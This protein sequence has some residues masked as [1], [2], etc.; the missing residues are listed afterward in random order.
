MRYERG[1]W[2]FELSSENEIDDG[3]FN[4]VS[5]MEAVSDIGAS[6]ELYRY[7]DAL[8]KEDEYERCD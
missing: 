6:Y 1:C 5:I 3:L 4:G 8:Q 7:L 2:T